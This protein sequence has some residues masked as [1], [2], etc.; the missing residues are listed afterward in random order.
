MVRSL[1][2]RFLEDPTEYAKAV[3]FWVEL[4]ERIDPIQRNRNRWQQP[5]LSTG[6]SEFMDGNPVFSAFTPSRRWG[7]RVIQHAPTSGS[8]ELQ[9][10]VDTFGGPDTDPDSIRELVIACALCEE[11]ASFALSLMQQWVSSGSIDI[12]FKEPQISPIPS[13][14][15]SPEPMSLEWAV[16]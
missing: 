11:T 2:S 9:Y 15:P 10:W 7:I 3:A 6:G 8:F 4:W 13:F 5:W 14:D 1:F 12:S 16:A